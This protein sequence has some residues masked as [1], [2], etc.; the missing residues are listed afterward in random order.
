MRS[1]ARLP[2]S[3]PWSL[4]RTVVLRTA[5]P[6]RPRPYTGGHVAAR[7]PV[8]DAAL[9]D[10]HPARDAARAPGGA[11]GARLRRPP[12]PRPADPRSPSTSRSSTWTG[13]AAATRTSRRSRPPTASSTA[14]AS[15]SPATNGPTRAAASRRTR[16]LPVDRALRR[17]GRR[18]LRARA[19]DQARA[20]ELRG[21]AAPHPPRRQQPLQPRRRGL[22]RALMGRAH[23]LPRELHGADGAG[24]RRSPRPGHRGARP[25][26]PRARASSS[27]RNGSGTS[28]A[29]PA[30][31]RATP[32]SA[33]S[34]ADRPL[35]AH[36]S[37]ASSASGRARSR[38]HPDGRAVV[39]HESPVAAG[40]REHVR[41]RDP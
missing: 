12:R 25:A 15:G 21:V 8:E 9:V 37:P 39:D 10:G 7:G 1:V 29:T 26:A 33:A 27:T 19:R 35:F 30:A 17:V 28:C 34:R 13:R 3:G 6:R 32:S 14:A 4:L 20:P 18:R 41:R 38:S 16:P 11:R 22:G 36:G 23:R 5:S 24:A 2:D 31:A 40:A